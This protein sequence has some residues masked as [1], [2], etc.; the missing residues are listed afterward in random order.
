MAVQTAAS[1][2]LSAH[3][4]VARVSV[5]RAAQLSADSTSVSVSAAGVFWHPPKSVQQACHALSARQLAQ[6]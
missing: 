1:G 4:A 5:A 3:A 6:G 2:E